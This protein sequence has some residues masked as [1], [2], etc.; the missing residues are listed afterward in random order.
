MSGRVLPVG[1]GELRDLRRELLKKLSEGVLPL[2]P[3]LEWTLYYEFGR[4]LE[5]V[6]YLVKYVDSDARICDL[7][8]QPFI[9]A[10]MIK[11]SGYDNVLAVDIEPEEYGEIARFFGIPVA[12]ADLERDR[13]PVDD[14]ACDCVVF[15]EVL[16]HLNPYYVHHALA[17][18]NR[19]LR[20][21]GV[22]ILTTPNVA[23]LFRRLKLLLGRSPVYRYHVREYTKDEVRRLL[24]DSGFRIV[25]LLCSDVSDR[26][27]LRPKSGQ[28]LRRLAEVDGFVDMLG[29]ALRNL[30]AVNVARVLAYPLVKLV[31]SLRIQIVAVAEKVGNVGERAVR[32]WG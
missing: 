12:R 11:L 21:S 6:K 30:N 29:F 17:E 9:L 5:V 18:I 3:D 28:E 25:E 14:G 10:A 23:S 27:Y 24:L 8:S 26:T 1:R 15:S 32:R 19:V 31:P 7:G 2:R 22:L 16:E 20:V 13:I 4:R